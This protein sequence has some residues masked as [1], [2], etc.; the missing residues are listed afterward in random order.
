[1]TAAERDR[2]GASPT[3][4]LSLGALQVSRHVV[5]DLDGPTSCCTSVRAAGSR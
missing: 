1:M 4:A 3:L 2:V 5:L